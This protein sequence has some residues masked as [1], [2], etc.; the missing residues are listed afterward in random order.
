M[1]YAII[2]IR[3]RDLHLK[4]FCL[5]DIVPAVLIILITHII[6]AVRWMLIKIFSVVID[7]HRR[8]N[9]VVS[10]GCHPTNNV[11]RKT[12]REIK[13]HRHFCEITA[14]HGDHILSCFCEQNY[15]PQDFSHGRRMVSYIRCCDLFQL[16]IVTSPI[17]LQQFSSVPMLIASPNQSQFR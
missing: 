5:E 14:K 3:C 10:G 9:T 8:V 2:P 15:R 12:D 17:F 11:I 16:Q 4:Q 1:L 13:I 7:H 6:I